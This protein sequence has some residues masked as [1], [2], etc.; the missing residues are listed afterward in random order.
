MFPP[1]RV[2]RP[3]Q[4]LLV[5][6]SWPGCACFTTLFCLRGARERYVRGKL[7]GADSPCWLPRTSYAC[8]R[9]QTFR[10][11]RWRLLAGSFAVVSQGMLACHLDGASCGASTYGNTCVVSSRRQFYGVVCDQGQHIPWLH[12]LFLFRQAAQVDS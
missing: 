6:F 12:L 11:L 4:T 3:D 9:R 10:H 2:Y 5:W 8:F 7:L 1:E